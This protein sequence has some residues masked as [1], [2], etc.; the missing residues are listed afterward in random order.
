MNEK[1]ERWEKSEGIELIKRLGV[2]EGDAVL[3]F[4]A[5]YGHYTLPAAEV[6]GREGIVF[7]V[8]K[9]ADPLAAIGEKARER[10]LINNIKTIKNNGDV[11]L[12]FKPNTLDQVLLFD[13]LHTL[14]KE[15]R[16]LLYKEVHDV[17]KPGKTLSIYLRHSL[18]GHHEGYFKEEEKDELIHEIE[19][20]GFTFDE[21][22]C[23]TLAHDVELVEG[24]VLNFTRSV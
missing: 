12:R 9:R 14:G 3:D 18:K 17:L 20:R 2:E 10:N 13:I 11:M 23:N 8:D 6:V 7:A 19:E 24:C 4:G 5:G 15:K 1:M 22:I 21:E 16:Y